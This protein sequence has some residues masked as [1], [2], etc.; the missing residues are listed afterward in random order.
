M[1]NLGTKDYVEGAAA[2]AAVWYAM[3]KSGWEK[4]ALLALGAY[5]AYSVYA[6]YS[7]GGTQA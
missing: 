1:G 7:A 3:K 2:I 4:Y 5:F 6:D